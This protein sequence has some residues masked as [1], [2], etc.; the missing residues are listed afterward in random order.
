MLRFSANLSMLFTEYDWPQR[1][2]V[3]K[4]HGFYA[5]EIQF[6]YHLPAAQ[7]QDL[8]AENAL[9]L[10]LFNVAADDL[11]QG[12]EGLAAV[13][14]KQTQFR[15]AVEQVLAYA[16]VLKPAAINVLPG[17][18][19]HPERLPGYL[20]TF[21][22]NLHYAAEAFATLGINTVFEAINTTDMPGFLIHSGAQMLAVLAEVAHPKLGLQY[23]I[24]HMRM[25]AE[26]CSEF[27]Q[28][29]MDK[30]GHIQFADRPGR[31][32]PGTGSVDFPALFEIIAASN[33][34]GWVG[35]EYKP[36]GGSVES[37]AWLNRSIEILPN[38]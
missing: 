7:L 2:A 37:L 32:Q 13:P 27:L 4:Q 10:V 21:K 19:L 20:A 29:H 28:Q 16:R 1:F 34:Q 11:L 17:R 22:A 38:D 30:I 31:G 25:M 9:Q 6:P 12:G 26:D 14:E 18:C 24:Y 3:A 35:A 23:D 8:L 33:Y 15:A 5:V 36:V